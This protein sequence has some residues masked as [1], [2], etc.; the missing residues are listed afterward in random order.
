ME[1]KQVKAGQIG[2]IGQGVALMHKISLMA[3][4]ICYEDG[5][6][7]CVRIEKEQ[8]EEL[9]EYCKKHPGM[10]TTTLAGMILQG[11][12]KDFINYD[13]SLVEHEEEEI[14]RGF[15]EYEKHQKKSKKEFKPEDELE[16]YGKKGGK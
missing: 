10:I 6:Q 7:I 12:I 11:G 3:S 8:K 9:D 2:E 4:K 15:E 1:I 5:V 16:L 13:K 14:S